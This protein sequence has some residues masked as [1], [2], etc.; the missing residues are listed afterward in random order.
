MQTHCW[1]LVQ[2]HRMNFTVTVPPP[3]NTSCPQ[4][5]YY[6]KKPLLMAPSLLL[7]TSPTGKLVPV[8]QREQ[9]LRQK[10]GQGRGVHYTTLPFHNFMSNGGKMCEIPAVYQEENTASTYTAITEAQPMSKRHARQQSTKKERISKFKHN[11]K[12]NGQSIKSTNTTCPVIFTLC[13]IS[14]PALYQV[15]NPEVGTLFVKS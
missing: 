14:L 8:A 10:E 6:W 13:P 1:H 9:R 15:Q 5:E 12:P 3:Q 2:T 11:F 7:T 4:N